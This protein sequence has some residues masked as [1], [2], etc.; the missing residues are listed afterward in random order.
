MTAL[1]A[2]VMPWESWKI[3]LLHTRLHSVWHCLFCQLTPVQVMKPKDF[4]QQINL[5][6][7]N[8]WG[9]VRALV[10]LCMKQEDGKYLLV[11]DPNKQLLRLYS[12]PEDAF[13]V[14]AAPSQSASAAQ[15]FCIAVYLSGMFHHRLSGAVPGSIL[16]WQQC[17]DWYSREVSLHSIH[18]IVPDVQEN[19]TEEPLPEAEDVPAEEPT[20]GDGGDED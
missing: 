12:V 9:I 3:G 8:C 14:C 4:A 13:Q 5:N 6:M 15:P 1:I 7:D 20:K 10:D 17:P 16:L 18:C 2:S 19:Y 11:K